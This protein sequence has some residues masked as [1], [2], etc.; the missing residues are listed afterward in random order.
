MF[1]VLCVFRDVSS[2][3]LISLPPKGLNQVRSLKASSAFSLK[4]LPPLESLA[5][6]LEAE[7]TYPSHCCAFHTWRRKQR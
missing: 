1:C 2:T 5:E 4:S 3:T 7:L 6:L